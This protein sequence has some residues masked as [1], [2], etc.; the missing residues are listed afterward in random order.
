MMVL[1][2]LVLTFRNIR[3]SWPLIQIAKA[4]VMCRCTL[5]R[6]HNVCIYCIVLSLLCVQQQQLVELRDS[7]SMLLILNCHPM[8]LYGLYAK[9]EKK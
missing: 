3:A 2:V 7:S 1:I 8:Q 9:K 5:L 4:E 6:L